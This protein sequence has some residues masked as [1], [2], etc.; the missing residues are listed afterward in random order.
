MISFI[1]K[2]LTALSKLTAKDILYIIIII[3]LGWC[4]WS[5]WKNNREDEARYETNITAFTDSVS[6][7]KSKCGD[8]VATK[9]LFEC[10]I[11]ELEK[12]N[13]DLYSEIKDLKIKNEV[14]AGATIS[15]KVENPSNDTVFIVKNDTIH[16]GFHHNF[17]FNNEWRILEGNVA[18]VPDS[19]KVNITKDIINFDYT[20]AIDDKNKLYI[21]SNNPYV[22]F[23]EFTGYTL[24]KEKKTHFSIGP[25]VTAGYG[26]INQ[27][28]DIV[29]GVSA[30]WK[31]FNF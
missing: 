30:Q 6:Y 14:L 18:Y 25:S 21:K 16:N 8:L 31:I 19:L 23:D 4:L 22:H 3:I 1:N 27:K 28:F 15:G 17:N 10:N 24:P 20:F 2:I 26:L 7:Y 5:Q 29:I 12:L 9:T 13:E 11:K